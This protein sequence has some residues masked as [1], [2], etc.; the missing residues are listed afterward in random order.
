MQRNKH[1][2]ILLQSNNNKNSRSYQ[3]FETVTEA[4]NGLFSFFHSHTGTSRLI[5]SGI[6]GIYEA[7]LK[8]VNKRN[9]NLMVDITDLYAFIDRLP[10]LAALV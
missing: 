7:E 4:M 6:V 3:D 1:T 10:D 5:F 9:P 2:I 8:K